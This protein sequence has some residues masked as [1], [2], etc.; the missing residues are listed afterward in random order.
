MKET[1]ETRAELV[2]IKINK[3]K[4]FKKM[5]PGLRRCGSAVEFEI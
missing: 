2:C 3:R 5:F 1:N 4:Y